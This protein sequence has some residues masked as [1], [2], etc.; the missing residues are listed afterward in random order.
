MKHYTHCPYCGNLLV[1]KWIEFEEMSRPVCEEGHFIYYPS[2]VAT[3]A[4]IAYNGNSV[5]LERRAIEPGYGKW[6]LLGGY[7]TPGETVEEGAMREVFE[8][9]GLHV[10]LGKP[11]KTW[12]GTRS[13]CVY[14]DA[15]ISGGELTCSNESLEVKL[16]EFDQIPWGEF[17]FKHHEEALKDWIVTRTT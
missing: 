2:L 4:V 1:D 3:A 15:R 8:E 14:Y 12:S 17:A 9:S 6:N 7:L 11:F 16:F 13:M 5:V 10:L